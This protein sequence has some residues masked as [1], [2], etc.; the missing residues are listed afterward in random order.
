MKQIWLQTE[1]LMLSNEKLIYK[2]LTSIEY[3][4]L[5]PKWMGALPKDFMEEMTRVLTLIVLLLQ[6]AVMLKTM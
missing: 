1:F 5:T 4:R 6:L 2:T 3:F